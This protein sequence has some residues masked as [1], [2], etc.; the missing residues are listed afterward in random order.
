MVQ[1][2]RA[3]PSLSDWKTKSAFSVIILGLLISVAWNL[4]R[5]DA[6]AAA[7]SAY[8]QGELALCLQHALDHLDRRPWS[9]EA[10]LLA[11]RCLSRL[12]Y[13]GE[14]EPYFKRAGRLELSDAQLRAFGLARGPHPEH[15]IRAYDEILENWPDN[16][17]AL[18]RLAAVQLAQNN[19][20]ELLRLADRLSGIPKGA[21]IGHTLRGVV[22]QN[23]S[24]PQRAI[25]C[26]ERVL[27]LDPELR[28]MPLSRRLFWSH[29]SDDLL[30]D[31]RIDDARGQLI[32]AL[33]QA[34]D[35]DLM[36]RLG[37]IYFLQGALDD[38]ERCFRQAAEWDPSDYKP[39][40]DLSKLALQ[41]QAREEALAH[42][43]HAKLLA[44]EEYGVL[45]GLASVYRQLGRMSEAARVQEAVMHLRDQPASSAVSRPA[46]KPWPR[47][48]L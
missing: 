45:Y 46:N 47:Y 22:F 39:Q 44:P 1:T 27:A 8:V 24:N 14:A 25:E 16:V 7:R 48:A 10:A 3:R 5:T 17:T 13:A 19:T 37:R 34:P 9:A 32:K 20:A 42:L 41:R 15:A 33:D 31:G 30:A 12:D 40:V 38:A 35:A 21:V 29:F 43:L 36:D 26:F 18:R 11:A 2:L 23:E 6:I 28:E 4:T